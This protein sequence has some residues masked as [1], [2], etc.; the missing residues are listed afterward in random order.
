LKRKFGELTDHSIASSLTDEEEW[1]GSEPRGGGSKESSRI[2]SGRMRFISLDGSST[3]SPLPKRLADENSFDS[4]KPTPP[5][6]TGDVSPAQVLRAQNLVSAEILSEKL[7]HPSAKVGAGLDELSHAAVQDGSL[8]PMSDGMGSLSGKKSVGERS[9]DVF[10]D[11][12]MDVST[13]DVLPPELT[14][15]TQ[16]GQWSIPAV[17]ISE[18][19][20]SSPSIHLEQPEESESEDRLPDVV[21]P[22][23]PRMQLIGERESVSSQEQSEEEDG[24]LDAYDAS[25][26]LVQPTQRRYYHAEQHDSSENEESGSDHIDYEHPETYADDEELSGDE[27]EE[28]EDLYRARLYSREQR[29]NDEVFYHSDE[30]MSSD[31][32]RKSDDVKEKAAMVVDLTLDSS[33][34]ERSEEEE[35]EEEEVEEFE[36]EG[37]DEEEEDLED[38]ASWQGIKSATP[39]TPFTGLSRQTS[40]HSPHLQQNLDFLLDPSLMA[41]LPTSNEE[42][43]LDPFALDSHMQA[44]QLHTEIPTFPSDLLEQALDP[45][46]FQQPHQPSL[47]DLAD[48][49]TALMDA[50]LSMPT[51]I[52]MMESQIS[53]DHLMVQTQQDM[54]QE[55][56]FTLSEIW[57]DAFASKQV[58]N[59]DNAVETEFLTG[60]LPMST[61]ERVPEESIE[62]QR[63]HKGEFLPNIVPD[64][65]IEEPRE[66]F[67]HEEIKVETEVHNETPT[68]REEILAP[69]EDVASTETEKLTPAIVQGE[70]M[71]SLQDPPRTV[72]STMVNV[73]EQ[74]PG[75]AGIDMRSVVEQFI[76]EEVIS[77]TEPTRQQPASSSEPHHTPGSPRHTPASPQHAPRSPPPGPSSPSPPPLPDDWRVEGLTTPLAYFSPLAD[78]LPPSLREQKANRLV[79]LIG[80]IRESSELGKTKGIDFILPLHI[81]DPST[82]PDSG[83]SVLLFRPDKSALP[84]NPQ[85]GSVII[86]TDMKV[87]TL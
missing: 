84:V 10:Q 33:D 76:Q 54:P 52:T 2:F 62:E 31:D 71:E 17:S 21:R 36:D 68:I 38:D 11:E 18:S 79:D 72:D 83:L 66:P 5:R 70:S 49:S 87:L 30:E 48:Q 15:P 82:G 9:F 1:F 85:K 63:Q 64:V 40:H 61:L 42:I 67:L 65:Q 12:E 27:D 6:R 56:S 80:I 37:E 14:R 51:D 59:V 39:A 13:A 24:D 43:R 41:S 86:L 77:F 50:V 3:A 46:M 28:D 34:D 25:G 26:Q 44:A 58:G 22:S 57:A 19:E 7:L 45:A 75:S 29:P 47:H 23:Q 8:R 16:V 73:N 20:G 78:I 69:P 32:V 53:A 4:L 81:V 60:I 55:Q 35:S 74:R